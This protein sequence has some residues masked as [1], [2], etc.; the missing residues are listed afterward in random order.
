M[1]P[2]DEINEK[3][4]MIAQLPDPRWDF[5]VRARR[6]YVDIEKQNAEGKPFTAEV[7]WSIDEGYLNLLDCILSI[8]E[9]K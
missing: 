7:R 3:E 2:A 5:L 4:T 8:A 6:R 1:H 9:K